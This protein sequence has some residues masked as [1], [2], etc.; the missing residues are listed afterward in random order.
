MSTISKNIYVYYIFIASMI[1]SSK[2]CILV[3]SMLCT[4]FGQPAYSCCP[5][6]A[7]HFVWH[8][9]SRYRLAV[10]PIAPQLHKYGSS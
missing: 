5:S 1:S 10:S 2:P 3:I 9:N 8:L 7:G 4:V 6:P